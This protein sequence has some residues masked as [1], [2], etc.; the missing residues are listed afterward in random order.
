MSAKK[1][2]WLYTFQMLQQNKNKAVSINII[3]GAY[4][5]KETCVGLPQ[6]LGDESWDRERSIR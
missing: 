2:F 3:M 5:S 4:C 1:L 6:C